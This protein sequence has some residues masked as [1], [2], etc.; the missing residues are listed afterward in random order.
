MRVVRRA[1]SR[2]FDLRAFAPLVERR[3][4]HGIGVGV[5][6]G[7]QPVREVAPA[8]AIARRDVVPRPDARVVVSGP[9]RQRDEEILLARG[10]RQR[11][12]VAPRGAV[13]ESVGCEVGVETVEAAAVDEGIQ[14]P[15]VEERRDGHHI[16]G[17]AANTA[18]R[19]IAV[20]RCSG[21]SRRAE[22]GRPLGSGRVIRVVDVHYGPRVVVFRSSTAQ[23]V[24]VAIDEI[25]EVLAHRP[26]RAAL[27]GLEVH[28]R[29]DARARRGAEHGGKRVVR[30]DALRVREFGASR[31][32]RP[33]QHGD[34]DAGAPQVADVV[35][36]PGVALRC[37]RD[38]LQDA[39]RDRCGASSS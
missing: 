19:H 13:G 20:S 9:D 11:A 2:R 3:D 31:I 30:R 10:A 22:E 39:R 14:L 33:R 29:S 38:V 37:G 8:S 12:P 18:A 7:A 5:E 15:R 16:E 26:R 36:E 25:G 35:A 23:K 21:G 32:A 4:G 17:R 24:A 27:V 34:V 1:S 6:R 28:R